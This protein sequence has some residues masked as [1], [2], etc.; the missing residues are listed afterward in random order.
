MEWC[1]A[2]TLAAWTGLP[3]LTKPSLK[4]QACIAP[5][6]NTL[7]MVLEK[8]GVMSLV[9]EVVASWGPVVITQALVTG[10]SEDLSSAT[11]QLV[12]TSSAL[13]ASK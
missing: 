7:D 4:S 5:Q 13:W 3:S 8:T 10:L 6:G 1:L 12:S 2:G 9:V 11:T